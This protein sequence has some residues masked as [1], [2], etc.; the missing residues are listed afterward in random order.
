MGDHRVLGRRATTTIVLLALAATLVPVLVARVACIA[1][2]GGQPSS[3]NWCYTELA[4]LRVTEQLAG[5]RLPYLDPCRPTPGIECDEY[6]VLTMYAMRVA[7]T[8][9]STPAGFFAAAALLL[10]LS[11]VATALLLRSIAGARS[12]FFAAAPTLVLY[13]FMNW[14]LLTVVLM[15]AGIWAF[16]RRRDWVAGLALGLGAAAKLIPALLAAPL[17]F[18]NAEEGR[19]RAGLR[20]VG[21]A[22]AAWAALD[23]P[24]AATQG[25]REFFRFNASRPVDVDSLWYAGCRWI[26]GRAPCGSARAIDAASFAL[27]AAGVAI[28]WRAKRRREPD[29]EPWTMGFAV[30]ILFFLTNK[31]YSPQYDLFLLPWFALVL[32]DVGLFF[33]FEVSEVVVFATRYRG[34]GRLSLGDFHLAVLVRTIVLGACLLAY[35]R[36]ERAAARSSTSV[37]GPPIPISP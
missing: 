16:L 20:L 36:G 17:S 31:V 21:W 14:D 29:T 19:P 26:V 7:A 3:P 28:V 33:A 5:G 15:T 30:L 6:P 32:P 1:R 13:G 12:L 8:A 37:V 4:H 35:V 2:G 9:S 23:A 34:I 11:A 22:T 27:F 18:R 10:S 25:W 24:F